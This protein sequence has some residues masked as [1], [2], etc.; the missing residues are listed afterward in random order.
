MVTTHVQ[1]LATN[2]QGRQPKEVAGVGD[3]DVGKCFV[4]PQRGILNNVVGLL[5]AADAL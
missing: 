1:E 2:L 4:E 3:F 5:P